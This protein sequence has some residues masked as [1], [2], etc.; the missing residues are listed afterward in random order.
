MGSTEKFT[1]SWRDPALA[2]CNSATR[3]WSMRYTTYRAASRGGGA[4]F[5][6]A[7]G[8]TPTLN[9]TVMSKGVAFAKASR[10]V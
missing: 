2:S 10:K 7:G 5:P 3:A 8:S 9:R 6:G 1:V 4:G